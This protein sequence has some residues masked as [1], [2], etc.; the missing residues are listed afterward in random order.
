MA[1]AYRGVGY[2]NGGI[3]TRPSIFGEDGAEMAI[4]LSRSKR[5]RGVSLWAQTGSMLGLSYTPESG[6]DEHMSYSVEN[7]SYAPELHFHINNGSGNDR[8]LMRKIKK[9][10]TQAIADVIEG[11]ERNNPKLKEV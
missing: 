8:D 10:A 6:G 3:A 2:A 1:K 5:K 7:N 4:P 11:A 9:V